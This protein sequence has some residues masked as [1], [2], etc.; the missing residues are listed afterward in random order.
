M[1]TQKWV[2]A[3]F[4]DD[5]AER[6]PCD[7]DPEIEMAKE[8][9]RTRNKVLIEGTDSQIEILRSD[10]DFYADKWGPEQLPPGLKQSAILTIKALA[11]EVSK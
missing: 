9:R 6:C 11:R 5:H 2:P 1:K 8:V 3:K 10:A 4:W 7:G